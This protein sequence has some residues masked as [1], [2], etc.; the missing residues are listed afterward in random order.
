MSNWGG[1][2]SSLLTRL[3]V[4]FNADPNDPQIQIG[5]QLPPCMQG[6]FSAAIFMVPPDSQTGVFA[7]DAPIWFLAQY[8]TT[9]AGTQ[10]T[11]EGY[12]LYDPVAGQCGYVVVRERVAS[13]AFGQLIVSETMLAGPGNGLVPFLGTPTWRHLDTTLAIGTGAALDLETDG[14]LRVNGSRAWVLTDY[15]E[16]NLAAPINLVGAPGTIANT[17]NC[18]TSTDNGVAEVITFADMDETVAGAGLGVSEL[19]VNGAVHA[20]QAIYEMAAVTDRATV[21]QTY[22]IPLANAGAYQFDQRVRRTGAGG[23]LTA[24]ATH[25][26][27]TVKI[28]ESGS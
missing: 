7:N 22:R 19:L 21:G 17:I 27:M 12:L 26:T 18:T 13:Q 11:A 8:V 20:K 6:V 10:V 24:Q 2:W 25:T 1:P 14:Q 16:D 9:G 23:T 3:I 5:T 28:F 4:P 15:Q